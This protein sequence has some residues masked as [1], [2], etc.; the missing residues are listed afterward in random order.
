MISDTLFIVEDKL[1]DPTEITVIYDY[2]GRHF[3]QTAA[4]KFPIA[5]VGFFMMTT[6]NRLANKDRPVFDQRNL[7]ASAGLVGFGGLMAIFFRKKY[8]LTKRARLAILPK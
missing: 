5:G 2:S 4:I 6:I 7:Y 8:D 1:I 3:A